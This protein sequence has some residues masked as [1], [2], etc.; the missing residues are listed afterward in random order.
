MG[1][2]SGNSGK[3]Q[4]AKQPSGNAD[5]SWKDDLPVKITQWTMNTSVQLLDT[6]T[7]GDWDKTSEYGLRTHTG[8][9][10]LF[11]YSDENQSSPINSAASWFIGALTMAAT[12]DGRGGTGLEAYTD[13]GDYLQSRSAIPVR[14][15]LYL[16]SASSSAQD[17][18]TFDSR[19]TTVSYAS[20]VN[21]VTAVDVQFEA[22]GQILVG[23][24]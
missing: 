23:N 24:L 16:R 11:Y 3:I 13:S 9:L 10:K 20:T 6:T 12:Q 7:L 2:Y 4:F 1:F 14:L 15:K 19:L 22:T 18:I 17:F 21:E 8:S 5:P